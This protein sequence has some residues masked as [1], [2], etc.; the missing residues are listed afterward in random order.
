MFFSCA[1]CPQV[2]EI[3]MSEA[4]GRNAG[5]FFFLKTRKPFEAVNG[6][7]GGAPDAQSPKSHDRHSPR[8]RE[9]PNGAHA[10]KQ[11]E[12]SG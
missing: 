9:Q 4:A 2:K 7:R 11:V 5:L 3:N 10:Y 1:R 12:M 6:A 8:E